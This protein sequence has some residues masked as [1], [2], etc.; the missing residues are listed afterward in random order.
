MRKSHT[1]SK[2]CQGSLK[3][4]VQSSCDERASSWSHSSWTYGGLV[5]R[6]E[7]DDR[8]LCETNER[9]QVDAEPSCQVN[10]ATLV[11]VFT[12]WQISDGR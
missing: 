6:L 2:N 5:S 8:T 4:W 10:S 3:A 9:W 11:N 7:R 12:D 1:L